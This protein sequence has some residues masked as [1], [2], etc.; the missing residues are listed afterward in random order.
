MALPDRRRYSRVTFRAALP[1]VIGQTQVYVID[2][3]LGG[4]GI[5]H[6]DELPPPGEVCRL[7][8][9]SEVGPIKLDCAVVRT[10]TDE[11][12]MIFHTG[13]AV[14]ASDHQ[15]KSRLQRIAETAQE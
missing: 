5:A 15:S 6:E 9:M 14:I 2:A 8:V 13:L 12:R 7:E 11:S 10:D 1:G 3:S 4:L